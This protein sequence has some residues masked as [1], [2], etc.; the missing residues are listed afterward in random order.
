MHELKKLDL[1]RRIKEERNTLTKLM[2]HQGQGDQYAFDSTWIE[3]YQDYVYC[4]K[5]NT[6]ALPRTIDNTPIEEKIRKSSL[7]TED[8]YTVNENIARLL[9]LLYGGGPVITL[10]NIEEMKKFEDR[11]SQSNL[12]TPDKKPIAYFRDQESDLKIGNSSR[13]STESNLSNLYSRPKKTKSSLEKRYADPKGWVPVS[14]SSL[15]DQSTIYSY[16]HRGDSPVAP[17]DEEENSIQQR[18]IGPVIAKRLSHP[19][20]ES[21]TVKSM[22]EKETTKASSTTSAIGNLKSSLL[23]AIEKSKIAGKGGSIDFTKETK[24]AV[25]NRIV[26]LVC[27]RSNHRDPIQEDPLAIKYDPLKKQKI[28]QKLNAFE[29][30]HVYCYVNSLLQ[31]LFTV[32]EIMVYFTMVSDSIYRDKKTCKEFHKIAYDY[33]TSDHKLLDATGLLNCF[34]AKMEVNNQ[35]DADELLRMLLD[36]LHQELKICQKKKSSLLSINS[37]LAWQSYCQAEDSVITYLFTGETKRKTVCMNCLHDSEVRE[38]F[39]ILSLSI[40]KENNS[41]EEVID[42]NFGS[43]LIDSGYQCSNCRKKAPAT[44]KLFFTKLPRYLIIQLKRFLMF[45][46]ACKNDQALKYLEGSTLK[47]DR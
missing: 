31:M 18:K 34:K 39:D 13:V 43:E 19:T 6:L 15:E 2:V 25:H 12:L 24:L 37:K 33:Q 14:R 10:K 27:D 8:F 32:R 4:R 36:Q 30:T 47:L 41:L 26:E 3:D 20:S 9:Y 23:K 17:M 35:Q 44:S 7:K 45:P 22:T 1:S 29:N 38:T 11:R 28:V 46:R 21:N 5:G 42:S 40:S 16:K